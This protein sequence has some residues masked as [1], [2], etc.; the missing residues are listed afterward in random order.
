MRGLEAGQR[1]GERRA[2]V[3]DLADQL[4]RADPHAGRDRGYPVPE[5]V[6]RDLADGQVQVVGQLGVGHVRRQRGGQPVPQVGQRGGGGHVEDGG[7]VLDGL[8]GHR[9][10]AQEVPRVPEVRVAPAH[11]AD[12]EL[13]V[14]GAG[15]VEDLVGEQARVVEAQA[16]QR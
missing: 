3:A 12:H 4:V 8:A 16:G 6:R 13:G 7:R 5:G 2:A 14:R 11:A 1:I 10:P 15:A 9:E